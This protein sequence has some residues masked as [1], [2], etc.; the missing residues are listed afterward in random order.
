MMTSDYSREGNSLS[1]PFDKKILMILEKHS[2][3]AKNLFLFLSYI[4]FQSWE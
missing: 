2:S 1:I 3:P 4:L